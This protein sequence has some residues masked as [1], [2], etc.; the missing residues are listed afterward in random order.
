M[1]PIDRRT[2]HPLH[3][4]L[5]SFPIA[6]F[7]TSLFTDITYLR[8][9]EI[10]WTNFSA[11]LITGALIF[12]ALVLLWAALDW[13]GD[14]RKRTLT[15]RAPFYFILILIMWISGFINVFQH[16]RDGWSSVGTMGLMLSIIS[17][18]CALTAGWIA[19][20]SERI[21]R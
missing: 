8:T 4:L 13:L 3:A 19:F 18:L 6:L 7:T 2:L 5:L 9:A 11:W 14:R 10:Q 17:T 15:R 12:G 1:H 21:V 20:G 16:S